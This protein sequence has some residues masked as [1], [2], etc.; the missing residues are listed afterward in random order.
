MINWIPFDNLYHNRYHKYEKSKVVINSSY[1]PVEEMTFVDFSGTLGG[2]I[3]VWLGFSV[4]TII[5]DA[6]QFVHDKFLK[7][8]IIPFWNCFSKIKILIILKPPDNHN[9]NYHKLLL[10]ILIIDFTIISRIT[11]LQIFLIKLA[12]TIQIQCIK[13]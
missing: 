6:L 5:C 9:R 2:L 10:W 8:F 11:F 3:G 7:N 12:N 4:A 1:R 13:V